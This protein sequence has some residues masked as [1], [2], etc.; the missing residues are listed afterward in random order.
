M[1]LSVLC[2]LE[3]LYIDYGD[4]EWVTTSRIRQIDP[5]FIHRP[6]Q[7]INCHLLCQPLPSSDS[8]SPA[9]K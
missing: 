6:R 7:A 1:W 4:C 5:I 2:F 3:V 8:W 9:A